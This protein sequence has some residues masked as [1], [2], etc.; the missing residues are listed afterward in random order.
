MFI[1]LRFIH[2]D[3]RM[4]SWNDV[5]SEYQF[6]SKSSEEQCDPSNLQ[7]FFV[8]V[9]P[10]YPFPAHHPTSN[11]LVVHTYHNVL[12]PILPSDNVLYDFPVLVIFT[13]ISNH[14][15][16]RQHIYFS[17]MY[18]FLSLYT[19]SDFLKMHMHNAWLLGKTDTT[20]NLPRT[21]SWFESKF[22]HYNSSFISIILHLPFG[23]FC[24]RFLNY[25]RYNECYDSFLQWLRW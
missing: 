16:W 13:Y 6:P 7:N 9:I 20:M 25:E 15:T 18:S 2:T 21:L 1:L 8:N 3:W 24:R 5:L 14:Y 19:Y 11:R 17:K 22:P 10:K 4:I 12:L 23:A